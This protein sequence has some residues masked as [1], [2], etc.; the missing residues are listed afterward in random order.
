MRSGGLGDVYKRQ[1]V[2]GAPGVAAI[3]ATLQPDQRERLIALTQQFEQMHEPVE[4]EISFIHPQDRA[5]R[6]TLVRAE[7]VG[8]PRPAQR[9]L[10]YHI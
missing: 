8:A 7:L 2:Q 10:L 6:H 3:A 1:P 4:V 5:L 9:M